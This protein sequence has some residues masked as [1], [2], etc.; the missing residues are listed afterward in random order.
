MKKSLFLILLC[1]SAQS[2]WAQTGT[3]RGQVTDAETGETLIGVTVVIEGTTKGAPTDLDGK[4]S[5]DNVDPGV[6]TIVV[7]YVSYETK[8]VTGIE[9]VADDISIIDVKLGE[10]SE[11][12]NEIV[13]E[14]KAERNSEAAILTLQRKS[15][16][17][18][19]AISSEL[20]SKA[21]DSDAAG[22][23]KRVTGVTIQGG[24]YVFVRGLGD[25]YS[26]TAL[27]G[28][29][30]PGLDPN[31]NTVQMDLFPSNL[32]DNMTVYK[33]FS[34][35]LP[36]SFSGGYVDVSTKDFP[37]RFT[38]KASA[39]FGV[40]DQSTF[41]SDY[42]DYDGSNTDWLGF[43]KDDRAFPTSALGINPTDLFNNTI[44]VDQATREFGREMDFTS[45]TPFMN[46]SYS[47]AIGNQVNIGNNPLGFIASLSYSNSYEFVENGVFNNYELTSLDAE[48]LNPTFLGEITTGNNSVL[49]GAL[50]NL[51]YKLGD[52]NK[53]SLNLMHNQSGDRSTSLVE[54]SWNGGPFPA[55]GPNSNLSIFQNRTLR[56][57]ERSLST[58]QLKGE[59]VLNDKD[60]KLSWITSFTNSTQDDPDF[61]NFLSDYVVNQNNLEDTSFNVGA[62]SYDF[63]D[64]FFRDLS[65]TGT[66]NKIDLSIPFK[67]AGRDA[68][69]K[70]GGAFQY[71]DR[72]FNER[73]FNFRR[74]ASQNA[75]PRF[76]GT[77][78]DY[79][80]DD[81]F[82]LQADGIANGIIENTVVANSYTSTSQIIAG[83]VMFDG[84]IA[85]KLRLLTGLRLEKTDL[86]AISED[87]S[88][89]IGELDNL[90]ILPAFNFTYQLKDN[91]NLRLTYGRT[92]A[93]PSP[94]ELA[95]FASFPNK[96]DPVTIGNADLERTVIDNFDVRWEWYP[97]AGEIISISAYYK[98][99][100]NPIELVFV[101]SSTEAFQQ[102]QF[103][104]VPD[105][106][107]FGIEIEVRKNL[108][109]ITSG[110]SNFD[111]GT[112]F[113]LTRSIVD[114]QE[115]EL[116]FRRAFGQTEDTRR[117]QGQADYSLNAYLNYNNYNIG[118][119][120]S[121][122]FNVQG[123][124][125]SAVGTFGSPDIFQLSVP[126]LNFSIAKT[127]NERWQ[128]KISVSN[129]IN[130]E[131][132]REFDEFLGTVN[133]FRGFQTG[134]T[135]SV[136]ISYT[137]E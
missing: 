63:P 23:I 35:D 34:P 128:T 38:L 137:I 33:T 53:L 87:P 86:E 74:G 81:R 59:H 17:V 24:K 131:N 125:L 49:W 77:V 114:I 113:S 1:F 61:R 136:G 134:R 106:N 93:R 89:P 109:F 85:N 107:I 88:E 31:R 99:M 78:A 44:L 9:V 18:Q 48:E 124:A 21:G 37:D 20:I 55:A 28:A 30:L 7:S 45:S 126:N 117:L 19:D 71:K 76:D 110:L 72:D 123:K 3:I 83:Y 84:Q 135:Y 112:N 98:R 46:Q 6:Y 73:S 94:R 101:T 91:M 12:L 4:F 27:N 95:P 96:L 121:L 56:W 104:N 129:I 36:G 25:R 119:T 22:A 62:P 103:S 130:P 16:L 69:I 26:K 80:R 42:L 2:I 132:K 47:I 8:K 92:L 57:L 127:F 29:E 15:G 64:R 13:V 116:E 60:L 65:E 115:E 108:G 120:S 97:N 105:A 100:D 32:V 5:I 90:D 133:Q 66:F 39:S 54:G 41:N 40:N 51:S 102:F 122:Y 79:F 82:G 11:L 14:A 70:T 68:K 43:G 118:L 58:V 52:K 50:L 75:S 10:S 111:I 67:F